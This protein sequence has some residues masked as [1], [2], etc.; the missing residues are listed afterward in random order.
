MGN[1]GNTQGVA[2]ATKPAPKANNKNPIKPGCSGAPVVV[3][4]VLVIVESEEVFTTSALTTVSVWLEVVSTLEVVSVGVVEELSAA[5]IFTFTSNG[6]SKG[7][8]Q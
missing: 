2:T 6:I 4:V 3:A 7:G 5:A 1:I 8:I